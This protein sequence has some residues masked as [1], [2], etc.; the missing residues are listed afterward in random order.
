MEGE[1]E[2]LQ[3]GAESGMCIF[4]DLGVIPPLPCAAIVKLGRG[5]GPA[6]WGCA[7]PKALTAATSYKSTK[8]FSS[9]AL[10]RKPT[11]VTNTLPT[12]VYCANV[13]PMCHPLRFYRVWGGGVGYARNVSNRS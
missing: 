13:K 4:L 10:A 7:L 3:L 6:R 11:C 5:A 2:F 8:V 9:F 12:P 1:D